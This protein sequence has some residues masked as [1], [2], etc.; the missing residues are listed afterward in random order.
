MC[1]GYRDE[2]AWTLQSRTT[3]RPVLTASGH[4]YLFADEADAR[5][6]L[7]DRSD[8]ETLEVT[9]VPSPELP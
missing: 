7:D 6:F 2:S 3:G 8:S 4:R 1:D 9:S 5:A